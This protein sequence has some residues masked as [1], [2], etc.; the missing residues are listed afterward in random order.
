[1]NIRKHLLRLLGSALTMLGFSSCILVPAMYGSPHA[2]FSASGTVT[3]TQGNAIEG[4]RV[5]VRQH[6]HYSNSEN[7]IYDQNDWDKYDTLYTNASG[8]YLLEETVLPVPSDVTIVFEDIDGPEHGGEFETATA[9][10]AVEQT[11][12]GG[13]GWYIGAYQVR[14]DVT[15]KN[16]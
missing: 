9:T 4:I 16:K 15:L 14:A 1:M 10:P 6:T 5:A 2:D 8:K 13:R 7:V 3:D 11:K 12:K